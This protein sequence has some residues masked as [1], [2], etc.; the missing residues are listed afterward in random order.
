MQRRSR[1]LCWILTAALTAAVFPVVGGISF[2]ADEAHSPKAD[3]DTHDKEAEYEPHPEGV[4][5]DPKLD[6]ALWSFVTFVLFIIVLRVFAWTPIIEGLDKR[7][8]KIRQDIADAESARVK[9]EQMLA[10]HQQKL[11]TVQDEVKEILAEARRDAEQ[12]RQNIAETA[13][14]EADATKQR[15]IVEIERARDQA[16]NELFDAMAGQVAN[17]TEYV[18]G[19][20]LKPDDQDQLIQQALAQIGSESN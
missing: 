18:L 13:K 15:A 9:A 16:L 11:E 3:V 5:M 2:A 12:A 7:E 19:N 20:G 1:I 17:A 10:E 8:G 6:L 4:P 14:A